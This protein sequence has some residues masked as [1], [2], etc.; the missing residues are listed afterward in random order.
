MSVATPILE[1]DDRSGQGIALFASAMLFIP[2]LDARGKVVVQTVSPFEVHFFRNVIQTVVLL[3]ALPLLGRAVFTPE[4]RANWVKI[5]GVG[6]CLANTGSFLFWSL[7]SLP[8]ANAIAI[9]FAEPLILTIFC[10]IFLGERV[11]IHRAS[12]V[13]VGLLGAV[14]VIRPNF[15]AF[16]IAAV[17][18][19]CAA[20]AFAAA[21]TI[22][23]SLSGQVDAVRTQAIAG[24][25]GSAFLGVVLIIGGLAEVE[26]MEFTMPPAHLWH[27][28]L[29]IG[30]GATL[31]Q[32]MLTVALR[33]AE[34]SVLA[35]FQ[36]L[37]IVAATAIGYFWF[38]DFPDALTWVGTA[39]ILGAGLY[40]VHRERKLA[41]RRRADRDHIAL[42]AP[43][44]PIP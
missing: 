3:V 29:A 5:A 25:F 22:L 35:P 26:I 24:I 12:A 21:M 9:F 23:R 13:L 30:L 36:Y 28:I 37:E 34:A 15:A 39:L 8:L 43:Q 41:A 4:V 33:F 18:P 16:G 38:G 19:L 6:V 42:S 20:T 1:H 10:V 40:V 2:V 32:L 27:L 31:A 11:G 17:L 44:E 14:V 7:Q